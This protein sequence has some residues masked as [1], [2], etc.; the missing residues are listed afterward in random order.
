VTVRGQPWVR[1]AA[2]FAAALLAGCGT[3]KV[4]TRPPPPPPI[5]TGPACLGRLAGDSA[6]FRSIDFPPAGE[7]VVDAPVRVMALGLKLSPPATMSCGLADRLAQFDRAVIQPAARR[8]FEVEAVVLIDF[9]AYNCRAETGSRHQMSQH[10]F[11]RAFDL[12]GVALA[13]GRRI[14]VEEAWDDDGAA[15]AFIH[16]VAR[17][18]CAWFSV[19]L[20]PDSNADHHNHLHLDV[21]PDRLC[22]PA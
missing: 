15:G 14:L 17:A 20:T 9:G 7:C 6:I 13:D 1:P 2:V 5:A 19:V 16:E 8:H 11:G 12:A 18:A 21:G 22:G 4:S 10:G 3:T